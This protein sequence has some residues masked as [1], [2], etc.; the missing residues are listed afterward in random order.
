MYA[1]SILIKNSALSQ[2]FY[3]KSFA[4]ADEF[5]QKATN[6]QIDP[7]IVEDDYNSKGNFHRSEIAGESFTDIKKDMEKQ[8]EM[9]ILRQKAVLR[10]SKFAEHDSGLKLL[11]N[12]AS[13]SA[14]LS[15]N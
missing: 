11:N 5:Y 8:G 2:S 1:V 3:Y 7:L 12:G 6:K 14:I 15:G 10:A 9:E 13:N 4:S